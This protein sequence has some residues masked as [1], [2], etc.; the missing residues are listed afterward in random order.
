VKPYLL[1]QFSGGRS[2]AFGAVL[3]KKHDAFKE[4]EIVYSFQNTGKEHEETLIFAD[5]CDKEFG[6]N[7]IWLEADVNPE[8]RMVTRH[9]VVNFKTAAR[10][11]EPY[12]AVIAKYGLPSKAY[13]HCTREL[14]QRP[15]DSYMKT[16]TDEYKIALGIRADEAHRRSKDPQFM[17]PLI[18]ILPIDKAFV[19]RWWASQKFDLNLP[20]QLGNCD[21]C[22]KK[23]LR[24][25]L[26]VL[27][28]EPERADFW[29][30]MEAKYQR[31]SREIFNQRDKLS[32]QELK[33]KAAGG[34]FDPYTE[35]KALPFSQGMDAEWDCFCKS[36]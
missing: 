30:D 27:K 26:T 18:D 25:K 8:M 17:Y 4:F 23:S 32:Y 12:E 33:D 6:L 10:K 16:L 19:T 29:I 14:K 28:N 15:A 24:K 20:T 5:R 1:Y 31:P 11:G 3:T 7:L 21:L 34:G 9:K 13:P 2:S 36:S 35:T 22:F